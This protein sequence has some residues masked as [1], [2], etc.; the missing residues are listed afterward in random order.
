[1]QRMMRRAAAAACVA[2]LGLSSCSTSDGDAEEA[3]CESGREL[4]IANLLP[5]TGRLSFLG[6]AQI[7]A[8]QLAVDD[9]NAG[10]GVLGKPVESTTLDSGD[11]STALASTR[12]DEAIQ[13]GADVIIGA[14]SSAVSLQV[15][16]QITGEGLLQVSPAN[17]AT[18]M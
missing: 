17:T 13:G 5:T 3:A 2:V 14:T 4:Q 7:A 6:P 1:M 16:D 10:G 9:I 18:V 12:V 8:A 11:E 15:I